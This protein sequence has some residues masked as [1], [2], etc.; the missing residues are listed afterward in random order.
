MVSTRAGK[1]NAYALMALVGASVVLIYLWLPFN[2][3]MT[4]VLEIPREPRTAIVSHRASYAGILPYPTP[5]WVGALLVAAYALLLAASWKREN[6]IHGFTPGAKVIVRIT[7]G[8]I[9][10]FT[11]F[12][13]LGCVTLALYYT[14]GEVFSPWHFV[15]VAAL[16]VAAAA[17]ARR[18]QQDR[19]DHRPRG[20]AK[21]RGRLQRRRP[22]T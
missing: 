16:G 10:F 15:S 2:F 7:P 6:Q 19:E 18:R 20:A 11:I 14:P 13:A 5:W 3:I 4:D 21:R 1:L 12:L 22:P 17:N 8:M 9:V